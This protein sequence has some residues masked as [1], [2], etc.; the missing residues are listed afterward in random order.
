MSFT[1]TANAKKYASI[2]ETAAAQ[3][4]LYADKLE[5]APDYAGQ[6]AASAAAAA[7]SAQSVVNTEAAVNALAASAS[8]SATQAAASASEAGNAAAAAV[9]Q[10]LRVPVGE[11]I[12]ILPAAADRHDSLVQFDSSGQVSVLPKSGIAILD[13]G[14]K[15][16]VSMIP[17][18]ALTE[19]F[20]VSSQA[21]MLAL[22]AQVGDIAKRTDLGYSFCLASSPASTLSNWVQLTD[23]VLAQL[24]LPTGATQVGATDDSGSNTTVQ[25]ALALK[26]SLAALAATN[27]YTLIPSMAPYIQM[28]RWREDGDLRGWGCACDGVTDDSDNFQAAIIYSETNDR[29]L[30]GPGPVR[31]TKKITFTKPPQFRGFMY[32]PPAIGSFAGTPYAKKGFIIYSEVASGYCIV[33]NPPSNNEY[34]R[35]LNLIDI[36]VLAKGAGVSGAGV[37]IANCGWGGYVRG[38]V[39]E[40]FH[41]GGLT[42]SQL[43]DTLFDQLEILDCGTDGSIYALNIINGS[44]LLAFNR[45]RL[46]VNNA[47]LRINSGFGF[48]FNNCHFE[49]GDY[50]GTDVDPNFQRINRYPSIV[51]QGTDNVKFLGGQIFGATLQRQ[52]SVYGISAADAAYHIAV[53]G[54]C[55]SISFI[56]TTM[57]FGYGSGKIIEMHGDGIVTDCTF[58]ALCTEVAPLVMDNNIQFKNNNIS[59]QDNATNVTFT[60]LNASQATVEGNVF[61]CVNSGSVNKTA[62]A[63]IISDPVR[64][65]RLGMNQYIINKYSYFTD[66]NQVLISQA[67][68]GYIQVPGGSM[69]MRQYSPNKKYALNTTTTVTAV[70]NLLDGQI[71]T[72]LN[73]ASGNVTF[74][75]SSALS[76]K[77]AVNAVVP[78]GEFISFARNDFSGTVKE[79]SRSF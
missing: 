26:A 15:I 54:A 36:H 55:T 56:G 5:Q 40:G 8:A 62:G 79:V 6:A 64:K 73:T 71:A 19:P 76:C 23:D 21:A 35:G 47:Q 42:L 13:S 18:I 1:D 4:K 69:D 24:G 7:S 78:P 30:Y 10:C 29:Q 53:D 67:T 65:P 9:S 70:S 59:Y 31:I 68:D 34:I 63:I 60:A 20:V 3:A 48:E 27:G 22:D 75:N 14:G 11:S 43:Q 12:S 38:L 32:S 66:G 25:G 2:S 28:Q 16:P 74:Q 44:N 17:A 51:F 49:Q 45:C 37:Q 57:G 58:K 39:V 33:I 50:P 77:G 46:E 52:M 41:G 61:G 72:F